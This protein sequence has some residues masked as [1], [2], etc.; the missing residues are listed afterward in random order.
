[1][2]HLPA[3]SATETANSRITYTR[4]PPDWD[5]TAWREAGAFTVVFLNFEKEKSIRKSVAS[6][7]EQD[8]PLLEMVFMDD[9]SKDAS[10][11]IMEELVRAYTGRHK[12]TV[13][14]NTTN[15]GITGQWNTVAKLT[16]GE[17]LGMF[18]ADDI[19]HP[20]RVSRVAERINAHPTLLCVCTG[21]SYYDYT[22]GRARKDLSYH[23][24]VVI[25]FGDDSPET[26]L[27]KKWAVGST[28][29][30]HRSLF[31]EPLPSVPFDD[32]AIKWRLHL[33]A[34]GTHAPVWMFDSTVSTIDYYVGGGLWSS[35]YTSRTS[36]MSRADRAKQK[37]E[38]AKKVFMRYCT[39]W[40]A[41]LAEALATRADP[42]FARVTLSQF[43]SY[44]AQIEELDSPDESAGQ[45]FQQDVADEVLRLFADAGCKPEEVLPFF[46][47]AFV[48]RSCDLHMSN[49]KA[50]KLK[51][52]LRKKNRLILIL[53]I[54]V[55]LLLAGI[56]IL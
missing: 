52:A 51:K 23:P 38:S 47:T 6:A 32:I 9:A 50:R 53:L 26:L 40:K 20:D 34:A 8:F 10:G 17:W 5:E 14:R 31:D 55:L 16:E 15:A 49:C 18:C 28:S 1:M 3:A 35:F 29:F 48:S 41:V 11:D 2:S 33:K 36:G 46:C 44:K 25:A 27:K 19:A 7:L 21:H 22:T 39:T 54:A 37:R 4:T 12:V 24:E 56:L 43:L 42:A 13:V 30:Y 45:A